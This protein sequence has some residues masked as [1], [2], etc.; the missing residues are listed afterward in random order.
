MKQIAPRV[1]IEDGFLGPVLGVL[2][3]SMGTIMIDSPPCPEDARTWRA[4]LRNMNSGV[5]RLLINLDD[6]F[7]RT[8]GTRAM[9]CSVFAHIE[10]AESFRDRGTVFKG[11]TLDSGADWEKCIG[12]SGVRWAAPNLTFDRQ[13]HLHWDDTPVVVEHHPGPTPGSSW[14]ILPA[15][16]IVFIGDL[17]LVNQPPFLE[18]ASLEAWIEALNVLLLASYRDFSVISSRSG[19]VTAEHMRNQKEQIRYID[20][21]VKAM[22]S[23]KSGV[24]ET[25]AVAEKVLSDLSFSR[26]KADQYRRRLS[27]GLQRYYL[28]EY[29]PET[30][31]PKE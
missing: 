2:S 27:Y 4:T 24:E 8:L 10:T 25:G 18:N 11:Q 15:E 22:A 31:I 1:H 28:K 21:R 6:H 16:K 30:L 12:L 20:K 14:V 29:F 5:N 19:L 13:A 26:E 23:R 3:L 7:D 17:V 9:D